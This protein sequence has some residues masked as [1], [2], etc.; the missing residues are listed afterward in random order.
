MKMTI[1]K[2][3]QSYISIYSF[4]MF[5]LLLLVLGQNLFIINANFLIFF[6]FFSFFIF[7]FLKLSMFFI[8]NVE[9]VIGI[10]IKFLIIEINF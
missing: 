5:Y 1:K 6:I 2:T 8:P 3:L 10:L 9:S 4:V 7:F